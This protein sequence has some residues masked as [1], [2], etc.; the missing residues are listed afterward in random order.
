MKTQHNRGKVNFRRGLAVGLLAFLLVGGTVGVTARPARAIFGVGDVSITVG[1]IPRIISDI[2]SKNLKRAATIAWKK[3]LHTFLSQIAYRSATY[4]ASG[5]QG[6]EPLFSTESWG[7]LVD[8]AAD[9]AAGDALETMFV[10]GTRHCV[11]GPMDG[12]ACTT[13][14]ECKAFCNSAEDCYDVSAAI[15]DPEGNQYNYEAIDEDGYC[16]GGFGSSLC[17]IDPKIKVEIHGAVATTARGAPGSPKCKWSDIKNNAKRIGEEVGDSRG[18]SLI[19][20]SGGELAKEMNRRY[21]DGTFDQLFDT[22]SNNLGQFFTVLS[23][24]DEEQAKAKKQADYDAQQ[25]TKAVTST[26]TGKVKTPAFLTKKQTETAIDKAGVTETTPT[27]DIFADAFNIFT[28]TLTSKLMQSIFVT[29]FNPG[30]DVKTAAGGAG[31]VGARFDFSFGPGRTGRAAAQA[32]FA[33]LAKPSFGG[34]GALDLLSDFTVC[35][36]GI[37]R[38]PTNCVLAPESFW[39]N[40]IRT[41]MRVQEAVEQSGGVG[42][43]G[44]IGDDFIGFGPEGKEITTK[45]GLPFRSLKIL[46]RYRVI[47]VTWELAAEY[48]RDK[49][50]NGPQTLESLMNAFYDETSPY[51]QMVDPNWVL[52]LPPS[53]CRRTGFGETMYVDE[54]IDDDGNLDTP[55]SR[56]IQRQDNVC[57]DDQS[58]LFEN[59]D[60]TCKGQYGYCVKED[61]FWR[62]DAEQCEDYYATCRSYSTSGGQTVNYLQNTLDTAGCSADNAGCRW[63]CKD[64]DSADGKFNCYEDASGGYSLFEGT[65]TLGTDDLSYLD[66]GVTAC[67]ESAVGCSAYLPEYGQTN[68]VE[69]GGFELIGANIPDDAVAPDDLSSLGWTY[70]GG[71][72]TTDTEL[73]S[74]SKNVPLVYDGQIALKLKK[75]AAVG[76]YLEYTIDTG[77]AVENRAFAL[78]YYGKSA[79]TAACQ[80][81]ASLLIGSGTFD[82][83]FNY[84]SVWR[85]NSIIFTIPLPET[86]VGLRISAPTNCDIAVDNIM[87]EEFSY[88]DYLKSGGEEL[89]FSFPVDDL[90]TVLKPTE[91][92]DYAMRNVAYLTGAAASCKAEEVGCELFTP[93]QTDRPQVPG[94]A[95]SADVCAADQVGCRIYEEKRYPSKFGVPDASDP[96]RT[97]KLDAKF[98]ASKAVECSAVD[99]GCEE[100]TNV[101]KASEGGEALEYYSFVKQCVLPGRSDITTYYVWE[102]D[103]IDGLQLR[104]FE[105]LKTS[106]PGSNA[107]CTHLNVSADPSLLKCNESPTMPEFTATCDPATDGPDCLEY[108]YIDPGTGAISTF[109]RFRTRTITASAN[110]EPLRNTI[111]GDTYYG[112][113]TQSTACPATANTCREYVGNAGYNTREV[114]NDD[115]EDGT[116]SGWSQFAN[117]NESLQV[118]GHSLGNTGVSGWMNTEK[119]LTGNVSDGKSYTVSFW[120]KGAH[121]DP[122]GIEVFIA[123]ATGGK[124]YFAKPGGGLNGTEVILSTGEWKEFT[125]GPLALVG[126]YSTSFLGFAGFLNPGPNSYLDNIQL[127]EV[128]D[129]LYLTKNS[130]DNE[131]ACTEVGCT[132]YTDR[133]G[134]AWNFK[135]FSSLC[136]E[137]VVGCRAF[138]DTNNTTTNPFGETFGSG[139]PSEIVIPKDR[140]SGV[141]FLVDTEETRCSAQEKGCTRLGLPKLN[142]DKRIT[143]Y[144]TLYLRDDPDQYGDIWCSNEELSCKEYLPAGSISPIFAKDPGDQ[145]CEYRRPTGSIESQWLKAGTDEPCP[146][147]QPTNTPPGR[148]IGKACALACVGIGTEREGLTCT[149]DA[150]CPG[151]TC[152]TGA[153]KPVG[154]ACATDADCGASGMLCDYRVGVCPAEKNNCAE[155]RDPKDPVLNCRANCPLT[156]GADGLPQG[157]DENCV[158]VI[159]G[160]VPGCRPY[161]YISSTIDTESPAGV[162]D[163]DVGNKLFYD[164]SKNLGTSSY[165]SNLSADGEPDNDPTVD[166]GFCEGNPGLLCD[167]PGDCPGGICVFPPEEGT[168]VLCAQKVC[169]NGVGMP[170][171]GAACATDADC[172][173]APGSCE[174]VL[175]EEPEACDSNVIAKVRRDRQCAEWLSCKTSVVI[176]DLDDFDRDGDLTEDTC[177]ELQKCSE[178]NPDTGQCITSILPEKKNDIGSESDPTTFPDFQLKSGFVTAGYSTPAKGSYPEGFYDGKYPYDAMEQVGLGTAYSKADLVPKGDFEPIAAVTGQAFLKCEEGQRKGANCMDDS[179]CPDDEGKP[180]ADACAND[181]GEWE[182][183]DESDAL[184]VAEDSGNSLAD[185]NNV[186]VLTANGSGSDAVKAHLGDVIFAEQEYTLSLKMKVDSFAGD[187][188]LWPQMQASFHYAS[189]EIERLG[190][191]TPTVEMAEYVLPPIIAGSAGATDT[192]GAEVWLEAATDKAITLWFDDVSLKPTLEVSQ[193]KNVEHGVVAD[194]YDLKWLEEAGSIKNNLRYWNFGSFTPTYDVD[195]NLILTDVNNAVATRPS[196]GTEKSIDYY[197]DIE[198]GK[199]ITKHSNHSKT[200]AILWQGGLYAPVAGKYTF[201]VNANDYY[202]LYLDDFAVPAISSASLAPCYGYATTVDLTAGWHPFRLLWYDATSGGGIQLGWQTSTAMETG[203]CAPGGISCTYNRECSAYTPKNC[204]GTVNAYQNVAVKGTCAAGAYVGEQCVEEIECNDGIKRNCTGLVGSCYDMPIDTAYVMDGSSG[205]IFTTDLVASSGTYLDSTVDKNINYPDYDGVDP[206]LTSPLNVGAG[207]RDLA[208]VR[209]SGQIHFENVGTQQIRISSNDGIRFTFQASAPLPPDGTTDPD[210]LWSDGAHTGT[211]TVTTTATGWHNFTIEYYENLG[212]AVAVLEWK[213]FGAGSFSPVPDVNF[214]P[215]ASATSGYIA[216]SCRAYPRA[217]A[218][219]CDVIDDNAVRY[220]GWKGYCVE[221][222]PDNPS[223]CLTWYP[224][225]VIAGESLTVADTSKIGYQDRVPLYFCSAAAGNSAPEFA[226]V[227]SYNGGQAYTAYEVDYDVLDDDGAGGGGWNEDIHVRYCGSKS[228][229]CLTTDTVVPPGT[230]NPSDFKTRRFPVYTGTGTWVDPDSPGQGKYQGTQGFDAGEFNIVGQGIGCNVLALKDDCGSFGGLKAGVNDPAGDLSLNGSYLKN[231]SFA[232]CDEAETYDTYGSVLIRPRDSDSGDAEEDFLYPSDPKGGNL[233]EDD[234]E[235]FL[236]APEAAFSRENDC[237]AW[238]TINF[239]RETFGKTITHDTY[240]SGTANYYYDRVVIRDLSVSDGGDGDGD[241]VDEIHWEVRPTSLEAVDTSKDLDVWENADCTDGSTGGN[242]KKNCLWFRA[243]FNKDRKLIRYDFKGDDESGE[244][245]DESYTYYFHVDDDGDPLTPIENDDSDPLTTDTPAE[246]TGYDNNDEVGVFSVRVKL[247]ES[248]QEVAKVA[249]VTGAKSWASRVSSGS[250]YT[251]GENHPEE[252]RGLYLTYGQ[253]ETS[254]YGAAITE[255]GSPENWDSTPGEPFNQPLYVESKQTTVD[256]VRAGSQYACYGYC[257]YGVCAKDHSKSCTT[258]AECTVDAVPDTCIGKV[259]VCEG[260]R[261]IQCVGG[262][263]D[264]N[265]CRDHDAGERCVGGYAA[266]SYGIYKNETTGWAD[267][268]WDRVELFAA[269]RLKRLFANHMGLWR[270]DYKEKKYVRRMDSDLWSTAYRDMPLCRKDS[271]PSS[272]RDGLPPRSTLYGEEY[273]GILPQVSTVKVNGM[274][275]SSFVDLKNSGGNVELTFN[276]FVDR[277]QEP[278]QTIAVDWGD[279]TIFTIPWNQKTKPDPANPHTFQHSYLVEDGA[280]KCV[281][282]TGS[283]TCTWTVK[284]FLQDNWEFCNDK[285]ASSPSSRA[286]NCNIKNTDPRV[287]FTQ[288][289]MKASY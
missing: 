54:Y 185:A 178:L 78:S 270:W 211:W 7:K 157:V 272:P 29:G 25:D 73:L 266:S 267:S 265:K 135:S 33:S 85:R 148:P 131:A 259:G 68:L 70:G 286:T 274:D 183:V 51:Y 24:T 237:K 213:P 271:N 161:Y 279:G 14:N 240:D 62:F 113:T 244:N 1:D 45:E 106:I 128:T 66:G 10:E 16:Q 159:S 187:A 71:L 119:E 90:E 15:D 275:A 151:G 202:W 262:L 139:L 88:F 207:K 102:G 100:Y 91:Y 212:D 208:F 268:G 203:V 258:S 239:T 47:P 41:G 221:K 55:S 280:P 254:P 37:E 6:Q 21:I 46:R 117:T 152:G 19:T 180:I 65:N 103:D 209:W 137:E 50:P 39:V 283:G 127:T 190:V 165:S 95:T 2:I 8:D 38:G 289:T 72:T 163:D 18:L 156:Y 56:Q 243:V 249:D 36:D 242:E 257:N 109:N 168:P 13:N 255:S 269:D 17:D 229:L 215:P 92:A 195:G 184:R 194:Y 105:L 27:G 171:K 75:V 225:D 220:Q 49:D 264:A 97:G 162:V 118:G 231:Y 241:T 112:D 263:F 11:G 256:Q 130:V 99:V 114:L 196:D 147:V 222:D 82:R 121:S 188:S 111:D 176:D 218:T 20:G 77:Y 181:L 246:G 58:C 81:N 108:S 228:A 235:G 87:L 140:D 98:V 281:G 287:K 182:S 198:L 192:K 9:A 141:K 138:L 125:I 69:N 60:G 107:P 226:W 76:P 201:Y 191:F 104:S 40:A 35:P 61:P 83:T 238:P 164:T 63:F 89:D 96:F 136:Q 34:G 4:I 94:I 48:S 253:E 44:G 230:I 175:S 57:V 153:S 43:S 167:K 67:S 189:G 217:D 273:C 31:G 52:K 261:S 276:S 278:L 30:A 288:F 199:S 5:G 260:D 120:A 145:T 205:K 116:S 126:D 150:E 132:T 204:S 216:R 23:T 285:T 210:A 193:P 172:G 206:G 143:D 32:K 124:T 173:G 169:A 250:A 197:G 74:T 146:T 22:G 245:G 101:N 219:Q 144:E 155:Y 12:K 64:Y 252:G 166:N 224:I 174:T 123:D 154:T 158:A 248:C 84:D 227:R 59:D 186:L 170:L 115:F 80:G 3:G 247:R 200:E 79:E 223:R 277:E 28:S 282:Q 93:V 251:V 142:G 233:S 160:G 86:T 177:L 42:V 134:D 110:C 149:T 129:R 179:Q 236:I 232:V 53:L 234:I 26:I 284:I 133:A 122:K 214:R